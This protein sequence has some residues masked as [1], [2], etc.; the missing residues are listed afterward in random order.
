MVIGTAHGIANGLIGRYWS[1]SYLF[2]SSSTMTITQ[3]HKELCNKNV[4]HAE[5]LQS[6][7]NPMNLIPLPDGRVDS[8]S[9]YF[10]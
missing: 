1:K 8:L 3:S 9:M 4:A 2:L 10:R 7:A 6:A 5:A